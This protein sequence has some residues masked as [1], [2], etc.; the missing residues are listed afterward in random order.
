MHYS[1]QKLWALIKRMSILF[2]IYQLLRF[3]FFIYNKHHF[4]DVGLSG[5]LRMM[6]GGLRFDLTALLYLNLLYIILYLLPFPFTSKRI[7]RQFIHYLFLTTNA[8]GIAINLIDVFYFDYILKR[9]TVEMLMFASESNIGSLFIE[10]MKDFWYGFILFAFL[11]YAINKWYKY[12]KD[13]RF[14]VKFTIIN[15]ITGLSILLLSL[16]LS[17][18]GIRGGFTRTTRPININNAGAYVQKPLEM[19]IVLNS[20]FTFIRTLKKQAFK[21]VHYFNKEDLAS[22]YT[23]EKHFESDSLM[24]RKN[25]MIII[26]ESLAKE[27]TGLLNKDIKNYKGFTPFLDSLML[28]SHTFTN[29]YANGRKSIDAM[30]SILA[31][32]PS[33]VQ[34]YVLSPYSTNK[35]NGIGSLL[36]KKGYK[37]A[38]FHG[39]PNGSMGFDAFA[40]LAGF[41]AYYG[42]T[43]Y[44][45]N[46][47]NDGPW[48]IPDDKFLQYTAQVLDT[49]KKPFVSALFT[50]SS[51]HPF[52]LPEGFEGKFN[53][54][55]LPIHKVIQYTDYS[56][57]H[58]FQVVSTK[59]WYQNTIFVITA[60]HCNQSYLPEYRSTL[61]RHAVPIIFFDPSQT[62]NAK[63]DNTPT[64]QID[65]MPRLLRKLNYSGDFISFGNDPDN[66]K[67]P[68][69]IN[70]TG[71]TWEFMQND[72]L[73]RFRKD[74][75]ISLYNY[76]E[77]RL[78]RKNIMSKHKKITSEMT[79]QLKAFIQQY[80]NRLIQNRLTINN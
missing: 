23:P 7:Y 56:L 71:N 47:D 63:L 36:K 45:K 79:K 46:N 77:D 9:S 55:E 37:S 64:Q 13:I 30:P 52:T 48:G 22:I 6:W 5:Y 29:A 76:K 20:T 69:V 54:G 73:L 43:E 39:A 72:Y 27:Y 31:S 17:A 41:D 32:I 1:L 80:K 65:I 51:H 33:L 68:F 58:F 3:I 78:L 57:K 28:Q 11:M 25:I 59:E 61:G 60:D 12:I 15:F 50:L 44:G 34:P 38:F 66:S 19:A 4:T 10:F 40:N 24:Q 74:K 42:M 67:S 2:V 75:P 18:V 70:Y 8:L 49:F 62:D 16:Y 21:P 26:V 14:K 35:I 53:G